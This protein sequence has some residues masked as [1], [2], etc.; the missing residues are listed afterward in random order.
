MIRIDRVGEMRNRCFERLAPFSTVA[1][2]Q[3]RAAEPERSDPG[4]TRMRH[5]SLQHGRDAQGTAREL[6]C[7]GRI[8]RRQSCIELPTYACMFVGSGAVPSR[9]AR[10]KLAWASGSLPRARSK[11]ALVNA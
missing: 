3:Q 9:I 1:G 10:S 8:V 4:L 2:P 5:V 11:R 6:D 7:I